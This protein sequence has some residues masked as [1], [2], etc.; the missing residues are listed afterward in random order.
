MTTK[1]SHV[2]ITSFCLSCRPSWLSI[3]YYKLGCCKKSK[4]H[5]LNAFVRNPIYQK[6]NIQKTKFCQLFLATTFF[7]GQF[8]IDRYLNHYKQ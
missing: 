5:L 2:D 8:G 4:A 7:L 3:R 1:K 6:P